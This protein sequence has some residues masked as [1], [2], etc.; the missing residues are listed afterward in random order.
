MQEKGFTL[1][2]LVIII[3]IMGIITSVCIPKNKKSDYNLY[4]SARLLTNEIR[5]S[6]YKMMTEG[7]FHGL[8]LNEKYY[9][10]VDDGEVIKRIQLDDNIYLGENFDK[11]I[12][13]DPSGIPKR[14]GSIII[15][16]KLTKKSYTITIVPYTGRVLLKE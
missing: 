14:G 3:A 6:R 8:L 2:E 16:D 15:R 7:G 12:R 1:I 13:F 10:V 5:M 9:T 4:A 11:Q